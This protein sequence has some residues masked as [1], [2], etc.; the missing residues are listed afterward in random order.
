M[1]ENVHLNHCHSITLAVPTGK[2]ALHLK[3][4]KVL[5]NISVLPNSHNYFVHF[6]SVREVT[7]HIVVG[8]VLFEIPHLIKHICFKGF[9]YF[10][11]KVENLISQRIISC[12]RIT[13]L[14]H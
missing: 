6:C 1:D 10:Q 4:D 9:F 3:L 7:L 2:Q 13:I 11:R 5:V 14:V 8:P 12:N